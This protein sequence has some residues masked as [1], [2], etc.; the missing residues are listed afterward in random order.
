MSSAA[1][2]YWDGSA[3]AS[4]L[5]R[6]PGSERALAALREPVV[7]LVSTLA[8]IEVYAAAERLAGAHSLARTDL[9]AV[10]DAL[11]RGPWRLTYA[12]PSRASLDGAVD[13][14]LD[15]VGR[16]HLA[17][18]RTLTRQLPDLRV[19]SLS[20]R[21]RSAARTQGLGVD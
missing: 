11:A 3:V 5:L 10:L 13:D 12:C 15:A 21:L 4:A 20:A 17:T 6:S 7:H 16:W 14:R 8:W 18:A 19:L 2:V 9:R 1:V